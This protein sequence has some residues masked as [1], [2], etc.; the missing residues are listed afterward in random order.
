M[1]A[2]PRQQ[3]LAACVLFIVVS[4]SVISASAHGFADSDPYW[5]IAAGNLIRTQGAI[6]R[7]DSWSFTATGAPWFN[8]SW[9][10]EV[11]FSWLAEHQG[12]FGAIAVNTMII[13][14]MLALLLVICLQTG[15]EL[16]P[17]LIVVFLVLIFNNLWMRP[18][19]VSNLFIVLWMWLLMM[20][21]RGI[22]P[23][24]ALYFLPPTIL[25]WA[26]MHGGV[27]FAPLLLGLFF[28]QAAKDK[29]IALCKTYVM[30]G[31]VSLVFA[32]CTPYGI[33]IIKTV[34]GPLQD[35]TAK[36]T[37]EWKPLIISWYLPA[38]YPLVTLY[39]LLVLFRR[40]LPFTLAER[41]LPFLFFVM[42]FFTVRNIVLFYLT[43]APLVAY[44]LTGLMRKGQKTPPPHAQKINAALERFADKKMVLT[45]A[46]I[47]VCAVIIWL[48]SGFARDLYGNP[49][50]PPD[51]VEDEVAF[52]RK[53]YPQVHFYNDFNLGG[54]IIYAS[55]GTVPVF[56]DGRSRT[57]YPD[58]VMR[59]YWAIAKGKEGWEEMLKNY[60][61]GGI[62]LV[63]PPDGM[64]APAGG[65]WY[66]RFKHSPHWQ[67]VYRGPTA[68]VF[69]RR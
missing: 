43:A 36:E 63:I 32:M 4:L 64:Q 2:T 15:S 23:V 65:F 24:R 14:A 25:L 68:G 20:S 34:L 6:P 59:D 35:S 61:V 19:Q 11:A 22:F 18:L 17:A 5:H 42:M 9:G 47:A 66:D 55:Q 30:L 1:S 49:K 40:N 38:E 37:G 51:S 29:K 45:S 12:W 48:P 7:V 56:I 50:L 8:I 67:E 62:I 39:V 69:I 52:I 44:A 31:L 16:I 3:A 53:N 27:I 28:L 26:N 57:V 54:L 33:D 10:W 46:I 58:K 13:S 21:Y 41:V 60:G